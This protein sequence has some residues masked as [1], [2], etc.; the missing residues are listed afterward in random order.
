MSVGNHQSIKPDDCSQSQIG[1]WC[2]IRFVLCDGLNGSPS[3]AQENEIDA[4]Q[5]A[6]IVEP[7]FELHELADVVVCFDSTDLGH[8]V[9]FHQCWRGFI[10]LYRGS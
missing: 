6:D 1:D 9:T 5:P 8:G 4:A 3:I 7:A 10:K 2:E